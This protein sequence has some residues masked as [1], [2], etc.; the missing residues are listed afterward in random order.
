MDEG[1]TLKRPFLRYLGGKFRIASWVVQFFPEHRKYVDA[2]GG[3]GS[4]LFEKPRSYEEVYN[5]LDSDVVNLFRVARDD[6]LKLKK[7]MEWTLWS[8][9]EFELAYELT[10]DKI[11]LARRT[12]VKSFM[13]FGTG[14]KTKEQAG[15]N[16]GM[17]SNGI[18]DAI[19][20][21]EYP[22]VL[23]EVQERLMGV[24]IEN[25]KAMQ[26][27]EYHDAVDTLFYLDPPYLPKTRVMGTRGYTHEM[28]RQDHIELLEKILHVKGMVVISGY[29]SE[30]YDETL[31][32]W[33][34][35]I[36]NA[37]AAGYRGAVKR[38]ECIWL[39]PNAQQKL[40]NNLF[41]SA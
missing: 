17:H 34:K 27:I 11:E 32:G 24:V 23:L 21:K 10:D 22:S 30:L 33:D 14:S 36:I 15:F 28:T 18:G 29:E 9:N 8:R 2:Y 40:Q 7:L 26:L 37:R 6:A 25:R 13:S 4:V 41:Y 3:G 12:I 20:W 1:D 39:N 16:Q 35:K 31:I 38:K 5:D 19:K